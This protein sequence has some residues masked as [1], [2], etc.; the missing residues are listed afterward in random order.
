MLSSRVSPSIIFD[1]VV[2]RLR[3]VSS[4]LEGIPAHKELDTYRVFES[5]GSYRVGTF[6]KFLDDVDVGKSDG[7]DRDEFEDIVSEYKEEISK[8]SGVQEV[9]RSE[10]VKKVS[11]VTLVSDSVKARSNEVYDIQWDLVKKYPNWLFEFEY[12]EKE[13]P[14]YVGPIELVDLTEV[15]DASV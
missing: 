15:E 14:D 11:F 5:I 1:Q 7:S 8:V 13:D 6:V 4:V 3:R 10:N 12:I 9:V 2:G